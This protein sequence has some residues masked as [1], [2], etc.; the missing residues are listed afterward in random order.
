[1]FALQE[2]DRLL[3]ALA[4]SDAERARRESLEYRQSLEILRA[5][6]LA[7]RIE[8]G[9]AILRGERVPRSMLDPKWLEAYAL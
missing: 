1:V 3:A 2:T 5:I 8:I 6:R 4:P 7:P 9:E